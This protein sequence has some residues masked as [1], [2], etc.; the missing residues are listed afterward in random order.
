[1]DRKELLSWARY[2]VVPLVVMLFIRL[3]IVSPILVDGDSM[4]PTFNDGD[5]VIIAKRADVKRF[6]AI[7]FLHASADYLFIKRVVGMPGDTLMMRDDV[8][9]IN[10][11]AYDEPYV[12]E[13]PFMTHQTADF[14]LQTIANVSVIPSGHYIVLGDYRLKSRD[15]RHFGLVRA[16]DVEGVVKWRVL[17]DWTAF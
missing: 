8:L 9:Y 16:E 11:V 1:M 5:V 6:D 14:T 12:F 17:H 2:I 4:Q 10:D 7:V 13:A 3:F 15:S